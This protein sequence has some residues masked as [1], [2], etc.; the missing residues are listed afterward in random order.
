MVQFLKN[1]TIFGNC[2]IV[3]CFRGHSDI[4]YY[5]CDLYGILCL[6]FF[7]FFSHKI[8]YMYL[9][10]IIS[11]Y[12]ITLDGDMY[13]DWDLLFSKARIWFNY[14]FTMSMCHGS[15]HVKFGRVVPW[16]MR[17][18]I[19]ALLIAHIICLRR[20]HVDLLGIFE[21]LVLKMSFFSILKRNLKGTEY[22]Y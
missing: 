8:V 12:N 20:I 7:L 17:R 1:I 21:F 9:T 6:F 22:T 14:S 19:N 10:L 13:D 16:D 5:F 3:Y 18:Q 2:K 11:R 15:W 4:R